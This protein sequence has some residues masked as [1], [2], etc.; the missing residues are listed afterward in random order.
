M[1]VRAIML[2]AI[3]Q[4]QATIGGEVPPRGGGRAAGDAGDA[5]PADGAGSL[6]ESDVVGCA[7]DQVDTAEVGL[8]ADRARYDLGVSRDADRRRNRIRDAGTAHPKELG[9]TPTTRAGS[10]GAGEAL[11][12]LTAARFAAP[13]PSVIAFGNTQLL[14]RVINPGN[15]LR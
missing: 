12:A 4:G 1:A 14:S 9:D 5:I 6:D 10:A 15:V 3:A 7:G 11:P 2:G 8:L 13:P